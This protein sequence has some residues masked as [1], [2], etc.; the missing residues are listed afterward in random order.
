VGELRQLLAFL[1]AKEWSLVFEEPYMMGKHKGDVSSCRSYAA[2]LHRDDE[3]F[4]GFKL[5]AM[6]SLDLGVSGSLA[7]IYI[8]VA[9]QNIETLSVTLVDLFPIVLA[10]GSEEMRTVLCCDKYELGLPGSL[11]ST[12]NGIAMR[13]IKTKGNS[14]FA[15]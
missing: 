12:S 5:V 3:T 11:V 7:I 9:K 8:V 1:E 14:S 15:W 2:V 10:N 6:T 4:V 13:T